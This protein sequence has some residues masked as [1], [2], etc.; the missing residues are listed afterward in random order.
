[1]YMELWMIGHWYKMK[2]KKWYKA[3]IPFIYIYISR[4]K[5]GQVV[6][7]WRA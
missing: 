3:F 4:P 2:H 1:M 7:A 5:L 6:K